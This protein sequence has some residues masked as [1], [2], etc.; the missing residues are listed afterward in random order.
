MLKMLEYLKPNKHKIFNNYLANFLV[1]TNSRF[2][3]H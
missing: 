1:Y 3:K 2:E